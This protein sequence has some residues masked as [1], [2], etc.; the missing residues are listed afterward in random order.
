MVAAGG[1]SAGRNHPVVATD[2]IVVAAGGTGRNRP[3][4]ATG[5][6]VNR[7]P[8]PSTPPSRFPGSSQHAPWMPLDAARNLV[9]PLGTSCTLLRSAGTWAAG[10]YRPMEAAVGIST[11]ATIRYHPMVAA[12]GISTGRN[13]PVVATGNN[14]YRTSCHD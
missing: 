10:R 4:V 1:I 5:N 11:D 7:K 9:G 6:M 14:V 8:C 13:H 12:G 2:N 3:V